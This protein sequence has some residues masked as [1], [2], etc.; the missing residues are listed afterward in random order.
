MPGGGLWTN[1]ENPSDPF[2]RPNIPDAIK[3]LFGSKPSKV[4]VDPEEYKKKLEEFYIQFMT[5]PQGARGYTNDQELQMLADLPAYGLPRVDDRK[6]VWDEYD[7]EY[8]KAMAQI[9][10]RMKAEGFLDIYKK[11]PSNHPSYQAYMKREQQLKTELLQ[12][13]HQ[14]R[15][16][17]YTPKP[18]K[19]GG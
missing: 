4:K 1:E 11:Y 2:N 6:K 18:P 14:G 8:S 19:T 16:E 15:K 9:P 3:G 5:E 7:A 17:R 12:A 13:L 10:E